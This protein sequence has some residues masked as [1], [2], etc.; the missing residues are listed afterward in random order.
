MEVGETG[1]VTTP[2]PTPEKVPP[3]KRIVASDK[4]AEVIAG[5][6]MA[7]LENYRFMANRPG[8]FG[9]KPE[10]VSPIPQGEIENWAFHHIGDVWEVAYLFTGTRLALA[11]VNEAFKKVTKGKEIPDEACFWASIATSVTIPSLMELNIVSLFGRNLNASSDPE[12]LFGVGVGALVLVASHYA[13]KYREPIKELVS[14]AGARLIE[15]GKVVAKKF[16]KFDE[17]MNSLG[18]P[19][20]DINAN[21]DE[22]DKK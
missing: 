14:K 17:K 19:A 20:V 12:D 8:L 9:L 6:I 3:I 11:G 1:I 15:A 22:L 18:R 7:G 21:V 5:Q 16:K 2:T 4:F 10:Q 13:S